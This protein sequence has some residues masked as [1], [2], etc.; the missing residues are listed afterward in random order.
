M[1]PHCQHQ[2]L[3][4]RKYERI[5]YNC[6][7]KLF[8]KEKNASTPLLGFSRDFR[9][10]FIRI[11]WWTSSLAVH[12]TKASAIKVRFGAMETS[13]RFVRFAHDDHVDA[14]PT[15]QKDFRV[16]SG[17]VVRITA[18]RLCGK[19]RGKVYLST[20]LFLSDNTGFISNDPNPHPRHPLPWHAFARHVPHWI[21]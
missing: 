20:L 8:H 17:V 6:N 5:T 1:I 13:C 15:F 3:E 4:S 11:L 12:W 14:K 2:T 10:C 7:H 21:H 18:T 16:I 9:R 19:S